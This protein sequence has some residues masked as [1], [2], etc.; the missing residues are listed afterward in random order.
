MLKNYFR[1]FNVLKLIP[2]ARS[3]YLALLSTQN[4]MHQNDTKYSEFSSDKNN[5]QRKRLNLKNK[6]AKSHGSIDFYFEKSF[7]QTF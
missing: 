6:N 2:S 7:L 3:Y 1:C 4:N 5:S